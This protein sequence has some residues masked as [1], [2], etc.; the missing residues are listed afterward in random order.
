[1]SD[2]KDIIGH[3]GRFQA[4][5]GEIEES[6]RWAQSKPLSLASALM[7]L[8]KLI[9]KLTLRDYER[10]HEQ[11][12]KAKKFIKSA[13]ENGGVCAKTSKSFR[14]KDSMDERVDIEVWAGKAFIQEEPNDKAK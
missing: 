8:A 12:D 1:M 10:R 4:Q 11:F 3:R 14:V 5:G 13:A 2:N 9:T 7:L 6:E